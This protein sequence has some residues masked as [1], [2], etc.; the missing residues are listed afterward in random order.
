MRSNNFLIIPEPKNI[1]YK[2]GMFKLIKGCQIVVSKKLIHLGR[3][4]QNELSKKRGLNLPIFELEKE[5]NMVLLWK[6]RINISALDL[7]YDMSHLKQEGYFLLV[8]R[9]YIALIA[10]NEQGIFYGIQTLLQI[11]ENSFKIN[12]CRIEDWPSMSLRGIHLD[13]KG[14]IP[15][16]N[17]LKEFIKRLSQ[18]K[19]NTILIEY[20]DKFR[21]DKHYPISSSMALAKAKISELI[22]IANNCYIEM[23]PL[24]QCLGHVEYV[25]KHKEYR[26]LAEKKDEFQQYC[27]SNPEVIELYKD[28]CSE[29][30]SLHKDGKFF[31]IGGDE[32]QF[33]GYCPRCRSTMKKI[34]KT[35]LYL[36]YINKICKYLKE[37]GKIPIVWDDMLSRG[38]HPNLIDKLTKDVVIMYW[39]YEARTKKLPYLM[40][41]GLRCSREW[42]RKDY[43]NN[44][45]QRELHYS[46][47]H[48]SQWIED[49]PE[50]VM[51]L[52]GSYWTTSSFPKF[53]RSLPYIKYFKEK[54]Y[55]LIGAPAIRMCSEDMMPRFNL[56]LANIKQWT[57][58]IVQ[59]K[60]LGLIST[61]WARSD[62]LSPPTPIPLES[63]WYLLVASGEY[64]WSGDSVKENYFDQKFNY[65]F[66]GLKNNRITDA[67]SL[68]EE[69]RDRGFLYWAW[70]ELRLLKKIVK[71]NKLSLCYL[72]I[73]A[74]I[75]YEERTLKRVL[76]RLDSKYYMLRK[77]AV[78]KGEIKRELF[79][80]RQRWEAFNKLEEDIRKLYTK[81]ILANELEEMLKARYLLIIEK[82]RKY[83]KILDK[84]IIIVGR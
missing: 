78:P 27:P 4:L 35:G 48:H 5:E 33:L 30:I 25:L 83:L 41:Q 18:Y 55:K 74:H 12:C 21:F 40:W 34:G 71:K 80:L 14:L 32:A 45:S 28:F 24:V 50:R 54:G 42:L 67:I 44:I 6:K 31:H 75:L 56:H 16:F 46:W 49:I 47:P 36:K 81:T 8:D 13:L 65:R 51:K 76:N 43:G 23:I 70:R 2:N 59:Q 20:E 64:Y 79:A 11:L 29:I 68:L 69:K 62:T 53:V 17:Y 7:K 52:Y 63:L 82:V 10:V 66:F 19:I 58:R 72:E 26:H 37:Q 60:C 84:K 15:N 22:K 1:K 73:I 77:N 38:E 57:S 3:F 39:E 9:D 61:A